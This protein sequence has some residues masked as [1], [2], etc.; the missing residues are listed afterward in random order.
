[1]GD[2]NADM[3][4]TAAFRL[5]NTQYGLNMAVSGLSPEQNFQLL[6]LVSITVASPNPGYLW[7]AEIPFMNGYYS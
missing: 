6:T 2:G 3:Y 4:D 7:C 5:I 1:M